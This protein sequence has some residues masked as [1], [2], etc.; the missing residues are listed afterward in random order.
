MLNSGMVMALSSGSKNEQCIYFLFLCWYRLSPNFIH[1]RLV[2]YHWIM[3]LAP[4][5]Y[6]FVLYLDKAL[7]S[8]IELCGPQWTYWLA[9]FTFLLEGAL[10]PGGFSSAYPGQL[11]LVPLLKKGKD[12]TRALFGSE[13]TSLKKYIHYKGQ[14][15][16]ERVGFRFYV[17]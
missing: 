10:S 14:L 2:L 4:I 15:Q 13:T 16:T 9:I 7:S 5:K 17:Q 11:R 6:L 1:L 8:I 3:C 12:W